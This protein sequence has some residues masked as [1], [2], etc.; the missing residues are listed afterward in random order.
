MEIDFLKTTCS[1]N[2]IL[3]FHLVF[4]F[5]AIDS[6]SII[7]SIDLELGII[8]SIMVITTS[9]HSE[10]SLTNRNNNNK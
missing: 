4:L 3:V 6:T 9:K 5:V 1:Q 10:H 2:S 7:S 8:I